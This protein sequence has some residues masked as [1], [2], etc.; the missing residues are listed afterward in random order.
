M[1]SIQLKKLREY[2]HRKRWHPCLVLQ[3]GSAE[4]QKKEILQLAQMTFCEKREEVACLTCRSCRNVEFRNHPDFFWMEESQF[5]SI[6]IDTIRNL[7]SSL[8]LSPVESDFRLV[9]L[10]QADA[11]NAAAANALLKSLEEPKENRFYWLVT[12]FSQK[13]IPT[14]RSR[15]LFFSLGN[16]R[17]WKEDVT[18]NFNYEALNEQVESLK[19]KEEFQ[20]FL[21]QLQGHFRNQVKNSFNKKALH[22]FE[23][24]VQLEYRL[25]SNAN[26]TLMLQTFIRNHF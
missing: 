18:L 25:Q 12:P 7:I 21:V 1:S 8:Q 4:E 16:K 22:A 11:L 9:I 20:G 24:C 5:E 19:E 17:E 3:T 10:W 26:A 14:I 13:I 6:K 23:E 2:L 15:S